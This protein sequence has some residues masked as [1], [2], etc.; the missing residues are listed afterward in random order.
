MLLKLLLIITLIGP[1]V[2]STIVGIINMT[3]ANMFMTP[4]NQ[5]RHGI[6][7]KFLAYVLFEE[8]TCS[9]ITVFGPG[10]PMSTRVY[11]LYVESDEYLSLLANG[12]D[13]ES[14]YSL[15]LKERKSTSNMACAVSDSM[16]CDGFPS[17][18]LDECGCGNDA[19]KC[20]D[21]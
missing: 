13:T 14:G 15:C 17:C 1:K 20:A 18:L 16:K 8:Q 9:D 4:S 2:T 10:I 6:F 3:T 7:R 19:F 21:G 12:T 11:D 5:M